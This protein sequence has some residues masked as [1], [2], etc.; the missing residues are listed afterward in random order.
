M[1]TSLTKLIFLE[2][3]RLFRGLKTSKNELRGCFYIRLC[4]VYFFLQHIFRCDRV[5]DSLMRLSPAMESK[6]RASF[7]GDGS[8]RQMHRLGQTWTLLVSPVDSQ[9]SWYHLF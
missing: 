2:M 5:G 4:G 7:K 3:F 6:V 1:E 8:Q 9:S